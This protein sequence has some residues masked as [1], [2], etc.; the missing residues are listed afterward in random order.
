LAASSDFSPV[1]LAVTR[2]NE[3]SVI[4]MRQMLVQKKLSDPEFRVAAD[5]TRCTFSP[6]GGLALGVGTEGRLSCWDIHSGQLLDSTNSGNAAF[7]STDWHNKLAASSSR[8]KTV[9]LWTD[10]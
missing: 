8:N 6:C 10:V 2:D 7:I 5:Y 1:V 9:T 3:L 4:D